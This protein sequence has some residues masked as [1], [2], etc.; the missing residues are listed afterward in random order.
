MNDYTLLRLSQYRQQEMPQSKRINGLHLSP[1]DAKKLDW[2]LRQYLV[3]MPRRRT[4]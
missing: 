1:S 4:R 3:S 2:D